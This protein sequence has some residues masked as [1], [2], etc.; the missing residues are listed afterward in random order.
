MISRRMAL[1]AAPAAALVGCQSFTDQDVVNAAQKA[2]I[3][4]NG[5]RGLLD[6]LT[7]A[8][9]PF[10]TPAIVGAAGVAISGLV[11][12]ADALAASGT[13]NAALPLAQKMGAY[14]SDLITALGPVRALLPPEI[15][16]ALT[17]IQVMMPLIQI[18]LGMIVPKAIQPTMTEGEATSVLLLYGRSVK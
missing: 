12:A 13:K 4:A 5:A 16:M 3:L 11:S 7:S 1:F 10:L 6:A 2:S 18:V 14:V 9:L 17:A 8:N 15:N